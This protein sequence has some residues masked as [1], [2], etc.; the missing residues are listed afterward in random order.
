MLKGKIHVYDFVINMNGDVDEISTKLKEIFYGNISCIEQLNV[1]KYKG[2]I[3][4]SII[5]T[6][7]NFST[8][9][10]D[11]VI[12]T[13]KYGDYDFAEF[14]KQVYSGLH[15]FT[16]PKSISP[17]QKELQTIMKGKGINNIIQ[18]NFQKVFDDDT[19]VIFNKNHKNVIVPTR[20][21]PAIGPWN[22]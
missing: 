21:N 10:D 14:I 2:K 18:G 1:K 16:D 17:T 12:K 13:I 9:K 11:D 3:I 15:K 8:I 20:E 22:L 6:N 4:V 5:K 7:T 19:K